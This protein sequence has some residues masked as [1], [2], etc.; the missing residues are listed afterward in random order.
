MGVFVLKNA[1]V[2]YNS[3]DLSDHVKEVELPAEVDAQD[4]TAMGS[5]TKHSLPGLKESKIKVKFLQDFAGS[6]VDATLWP[7]YNTGTS[8]TLV[9]KPDAGATSAT[10]PKF[11]ATVYPA[12]YPPIGGGVGDVAETEVT[13]EISSGDVVRAIAD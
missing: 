8:R 13:F 9:I 11:T 6:K 7:D 5:N 2:V 1:S 3:V 4:S 12:S 10:N